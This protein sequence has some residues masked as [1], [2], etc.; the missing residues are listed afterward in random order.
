MLQFAILPSTCRFAALGLCALIIN[1]TKTPL[2]SAERRVE[3]V[4][5]SLQKEAPV[6]VIILNGLLADF[7]K[8]N[9]IN[10]VIRG[11]RAV[12]DFEFEF[13]MALMNRHLYPKLETIFL[14]PQEEHTYL[15]SRLV[16]EV[17]RL[18]GDISELVPPCVAQAFSR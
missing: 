4:R 9:Q 17:A 7:A 15:S 13:Q 10:V 2:F 5:Q 14:T 11:L 3:F 16:K 1:N 12:S 8:K 18:G 6:Q